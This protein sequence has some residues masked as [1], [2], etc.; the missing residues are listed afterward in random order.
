[1]NVSA[2]LGRDRLSA[3]IDR[4]RRLAHQHAAAAEMLTFYAD[5]AR[6]QLTLLGELPWLLI[7][8]DARRS[9][10]ADALDVRAASTLV[11]N[12]LGWLDTRLPQGLA[13][14]ARALASRTAGEWQSSIALLWSRG[15]SEVEGIGEVEQFVVE[16]LLQPLAESLALTHPEIT[17]SL[18]SNRQITSSPNSDRQITS[19][20]DPDR[21]I[22]SSPDRQIQFVPTAPHVCPCCSG[23]PL[24]ATLRERGHG[25]HRSLICGFCLTEWPM[26]R[27]VCCSCG[28]REFD[29]LAVYRAEQFPA[30][31]IDA[32]GR[33]HTYI[34]TIDLTVDGAANPIVD[35]LASLPLDLWAAEQGYRRLRG[36]L[37]RV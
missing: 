19:S 7:S 11:P 3:R 32:C 35:D 33:C 17:S 4:A 8:P 21:Q 18:N 30:A 26:A 20:L 29:S 13:S 23:R 31:R 15:G 28:E 6:F 25:A 1:V 34:K 5:L 16:A 22:T 37:L 14:E 12:L 24:L 10:F 27:L 2:D 36:N 9:A